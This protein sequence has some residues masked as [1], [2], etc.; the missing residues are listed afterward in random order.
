[1]HGQQNVKKKLHKNHLHWRK[2]GDVLIIALALFEVHAFRFLNEVEEQ[3]N[4][5]TSVHGSTLA[6]TETD[7]VRL[8]SEKQKIL[9]C[10][11]SLLT[12]FGSS[13]TFN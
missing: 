12:T 2:S 11:Q 9:R 3:E 8:R 4:D 1:M 13:Q 7:T 5:I 10:S 6:K